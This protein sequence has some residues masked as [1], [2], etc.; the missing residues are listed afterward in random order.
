MNKNESV[1]VSISFSKD[2]EKSILIV[3]SQADGKMEILNAI[4]G[5]EAVDL[6][7]QLTIPKKEGV[8]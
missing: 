5:Q 3:G 6:Y 1:I 7:A 4:S 8:K 2:V